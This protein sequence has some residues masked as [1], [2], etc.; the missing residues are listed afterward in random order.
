MQTNISESFREAEAAWRDYES[1]QDHYLYQ[2]FDWLACWYETIGR[3]RSLKP[4]LVDVRD[5]EGSPLAFLPLA[6]EKRLLGTALIWLGGD[7]TDYHGPLLTAEG[8]AALDDRAITYLF[9]ALRKRFPSILY[10]DFRRQPAVIGGFDNPFF[11]MGKV[12]RSEAA[13]A[14][15]LDGDWPSYYAAKRSKKTRHNDR[16]KRRKLENLGTLAFVVA[17]T[18]D[19]IDAQVAAMLMQKDSYVARLGQINSLLQ[20]G[21]GEFLKRIAGGQAMVGRPLLC[22]LKL[23]DQILAVQWGVLH[24]RRFYSIV[25]SYDDGAFSRFSTGDIL[26]RELLARCF[27]DDVEIL[28]FTCGDEPYKLAW[29]DQS[30]ELEDRSLPLSAAG[31]VIVGANLAMASIRHHARSLR[32]LRDAVAAVRGWTRRGILRRPAASAS[33]P[34]RHAELRKRLALEPES[35]SDGLVGLGHLRTE[36]HRVV[37]ST[38]LEKRQVTPPHR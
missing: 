5:H 14:A 4:C 38:G 10:A 16:R 18:P 28:D 30:L 21:H 19:E 6:L 36:P 13:L 29:C 22:A 9:K 32:T 27:E 35:R 26:L 20:R 37:T 17:A 33:S 23:D 8:S 1:L 7:I 2:T 15:T 25:A 34:A 11:K 24:R 31:R 12:I 3:H